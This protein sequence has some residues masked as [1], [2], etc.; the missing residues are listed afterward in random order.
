MVSRVDLTTG[1][2]PDS[3]GDVSGPCDKGPVG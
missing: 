2:R 3:E 1:L